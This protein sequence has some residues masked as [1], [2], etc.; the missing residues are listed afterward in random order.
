MHILFIY[1]LSFNFA[2]SFHGHIPSVWW[3]SRYNYLNPFY[4]TYTIQKLF[5]VE[6]KFLLAWAVANTAVLKTLF[7]EV[8]NNLSIHLYILYLWQVNLRNHISSK[9]FVLS[10]LLIQKVVNFNR[11]FLTYY[12]LQIV[13]QKHYYFRKLSTIHQILQSVL[14]WAKQAGSKNNCQIIGWHFIFLFE[15]D[16]APF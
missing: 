1:H 9:C 12:P 4:F 3:I 16:D 8:G 14:L 15:S 5:V 2:S 7:R 11:L 13:Y 10:R 6:W